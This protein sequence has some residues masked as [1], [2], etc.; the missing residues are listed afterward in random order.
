[1]PPLQD[2]DLL[3]IGRPEDDGTTSNYKI[4]WAQLKDEISA[5][6]F[7]QTETDGDSSSNS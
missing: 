5:L 3:I 2:D 1:M 7:N 4:T 6:P